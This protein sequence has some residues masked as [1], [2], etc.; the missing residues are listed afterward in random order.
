M[1][2]HVGQQ[3]VITGVARWYS[4]TS[5][6]DSVLIWNILLILGKSYIISLVNWF[7]L[8]RIYSLCF[9]SAVFCSILWV[10]LMVMFRLLPAA[11]KASRGFC[12]IEFRY[13][14]LQMVCSVVILGR[15][16]VSWELVRCLKAK[17]QF[18]S[19]LPGPS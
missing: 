14:F 7:L 11:V 1:H 16:S 5:D 19:L 12:C 8:V 2:V 6:C 17:V 4:T 3:G 9:C 18:S 13:Y 10:S 15:F